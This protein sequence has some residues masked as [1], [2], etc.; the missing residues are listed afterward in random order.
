[1][2]ERH[3]CRLLGQGRGT[4]RY[5]GAAR[6]DEGALRKA[7]IALATKY[8]RYGY[9]RITA[10]LRTAGWR[11]GKDRVQRIWRREGL[12]V[13]QKQKPRARLWLNDGSC[14]RLRPARP[15]HVWSYKRHP[16]SASLTMARWLVVAAVLLS[17]PSMFTAFS[18]IPRHCPTHV[19]VYEFERTPV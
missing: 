10:L 3:A 1:M 14:V 17:P 9:R 2:S 8:G 7:V 11:V 6:S 15:N 19:R 16:L 12:K 13:P 4:Q 18:T 5:E